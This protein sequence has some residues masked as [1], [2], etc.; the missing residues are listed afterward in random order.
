MDPV[1]PVYVASVETWAVE[2]LHCLVPRPQG[3]QCV[4]D[5]GTDTTVFSR[6]TLRT[7]TVLEV[8]RLHHGTTLDIVYEIL[9]SGFRVGDGH[10]KK[11]SNQERDVRDARP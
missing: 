2:F 3:W 7:T 10:H 8:E 5:I 9:R 11:Q 1:D 6:G 4:H